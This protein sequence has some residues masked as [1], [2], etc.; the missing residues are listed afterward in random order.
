MHP[1]GMTDEKKQTREGALIDAARLRRSLKIRRVAPEAG[2]SEGRWRQIV[3]GYQS[4]GRGQVVD[5]IA[6][7][8]TLARMAKAVGVTATELRKA[9]RTDAALELERLVVFEQQPTKA[10]DAARI[11][12]EQL[13]PALA[14][15]SDRELLLEVE[16]RLLSSA[17]ELQARG[18]TTLT[19]RT[20]P[21]GRVALSSI[22]PPKERNHDG[23]RP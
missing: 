10:A 4:A 3:N 15:F 17:A 22:P 21:E 20:D 2:I 11:A 1:Q 19:W 8:E 18:A 16:M 23:D 13:N 12:R 5:V 7:A 6:P 14:R 9:G